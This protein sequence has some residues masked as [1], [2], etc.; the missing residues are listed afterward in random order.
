V[1]PE[2]LWMLGVGLVVVCGV[3]VWIDR[4]IEGEGA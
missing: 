3:S 2:R 1:P 4:W